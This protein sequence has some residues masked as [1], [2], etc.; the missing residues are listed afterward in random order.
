MKLS[1]VKHLIP[2]M[3]LLWCVTEASAGNENLKRLAAK[4]IPN[5]EENIKFEQVT[6]DNDFFELESG[7][8]KLIIRGNNDGSMARGLNHY[9]R[10]Y[11]HATTSWTGQNIQIVDVLP[12]V[13]D[14]IRVEATLPLRYYLNYCT[15]SYSMAYWDWDK[16]EE[17][18]DWMAMQGINMP[19][20]SV[21]GQYAV[22]QNTLARLGYSKDEILNFLPGPGYEAWWLMGNLEGF[23]GP[24]SQQFIDRQTELQRKMLQRMREYGM[25]PILQGFYGMVP[26]NM[27]QKYPKADIRDIGKWITY[28]RPAFLV[29]TDSLFPKVAK[30]YYEEQEKLF[31]Q[32]LYFAG[33]PFHEG[34]NAKGVNITES[35]SIIYQSMKERNPKAA[36]VLQGWGGNPSTELLNGLK[37]GEAV[38]LDLMAC[39]RPQWGGVPSSVA[40]RSEGY[41]HHNWIWCSLPNFGGRVGIYGK[42]NSYATGV[43]VAKNHPKGKLRACL[44]FP[45]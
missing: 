31:G 32:A 17:E 33:D 25:K 11:L 19:L 39:G 26:N 28:Q 13:A 7:N 40:H 38:I 41:L 45:Q 23:G 30:I 43:V 18:I 16:W 6:G 9:L 29:P 34:G 1:F 12:T 42:L 8:G 37:Q 5:Q 2:M 35:A 24:V 14:K 3:A 22:W 44:N 10:H 21:I 4:M 36:W 27:I 20:V 15:Y